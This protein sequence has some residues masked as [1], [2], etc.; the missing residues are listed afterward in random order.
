[1][2]IFDAQNQNATF[3]IRKS[4]HIFRH[5]IPNRT[6]IPRA[7]ATL[8]PLKQRLAFKV[9]ALVLMKEGCDIEDRNAHRFS[10][11]TDALSSRFLWGIVR[12][13][14]FEKQTQTAFED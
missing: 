11:I 6:P 4:C 1:M 9:L 12:Q 13:S 3:R 7:F 14:D 5:L 2:I 10:R 8:K